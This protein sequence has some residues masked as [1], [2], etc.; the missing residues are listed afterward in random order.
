VRLARMLQE[1]GLRVTKL[2]RCPSVLM[3]TSVVHP[4][5]VNLAYA[6]V[7]LPGIGSSVSEASF[8]ESPL[9][10]RRICRLRG[11]KKLNQ[12]DRGQDILEYRLARGATGLVA[13]DRFSEGRAIRSFQ[14]VQRGNRRLE[15]QRRM[16]RA[17]SACWRK[18][19]SALK[20][21]VPA[22]RA[23]PRLES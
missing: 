15:N 21:R 18:Q 10:T 11:C 4:T 23:L 9:R 17:A 1:C 5:S 20:K 7:A 3:A 16:A 6:Q 12:P 14:F 8:P 22:R 13:Q 2:G 19:T